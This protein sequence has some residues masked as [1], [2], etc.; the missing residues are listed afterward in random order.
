MHGFDEQ[1]PDWE[2]S[3]ISTHDRHPT[4]RSATGLLLAWAVPAWAVLGWA[5]QACPADTLVVHWNG[6]GDFVA[7]Q[8]AIDAAQSGDTIVVMPSTGAPAGA[9]V[10]NLSIAGK[11]LILRSVDPDDP[12]VVAATIIDGGAAGSVITCS[13]TWPAPAAP[14]EIAGF[15]I[16]NG[17]AAAGAGINLHATSPTVRRCLIRENHASGASTIVGGA[18]SGINSSARLRDCIIV[19]NT[20]SATLDAYGCVG[21]LYG[22]PIVERC[23]IGGNSIAAANNVYAGGIYLFNTAASVT[24]CRIVGNSGSG[25][26]TAQGGGIGISGNTAPRIASCTIADNTLA[27]PNSFGGAVRCVNLTKPVIEHCTI[28]RNSARVGGAIWAYNQGT[29]ISLRDSLIWDNPTLAGLPITLSLASHLSIAFSDVQGGMGSVFLEGS[30][31]A[32]WLAGNI[33]LPPEFADPAGADNDPATWEDNDYHLGAG[34]PCINRGNPA[35][36][37]APGETDIDGD[38]RILG[39]ITDMGSD[40]SYAG[41][42]GDLNGDGSIDAGDYHELAPCLGGPVAG[43]APECRCADLD[44][45]GHVDLADYGWL[46][47]L[48]E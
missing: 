40:E 33:D 10:E 9:Y 26:G 7:I 15:T 16:R 48:I 34:S 45:D 35:F 12:A 21:F 2:G 46:Q 17:A 6:S 38:A 8:P 29:E 47:R 18:V 36:T 13:V 43:S 23:T 31:H 11:G 14:A 22:A 32:I 25:G 37:G 3:T 27:G 39:C 44:G 41:V 20:T 1:A 4:S 28:T 19:D 30:A 24:G 42:D 5:G